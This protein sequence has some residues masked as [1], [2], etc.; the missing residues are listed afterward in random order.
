M[1]D[2]PIYN[3]PIDLLLEH[4]GC[5]EEGKGMYYSPLR[6]ET[7]PSLHV[8]KVTM[9]GTITEPASEEQTYS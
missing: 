6:N 2:N 3:Y 4:L 5:K 9:Y 1:F 7:T 8:N